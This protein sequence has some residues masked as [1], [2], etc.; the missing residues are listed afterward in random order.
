MK[1]T[2]CRSLHFIL[3]TYF[4]AACSQEWTPSQLNAYVGQFNDRWDTSPISVCFEQEGRYELDRQTLQEAI[5]LEFARAGITFHGWDTC[6]EESHGIRISFDRQAESSWTQGFGHHLDGRFA[7]IVM[8][9]KH[10]CPLPYS[11]SHCQKN[12][13][14]H[15][16]GHALGLRHE[17][18]RRDNTSCFFDQT[19]KNGEDDAIQISTFDAL[20]VMNY[21]HL[22][23]ANEERQVLSLSQGDIAA[24]K[25]LY[26]G[27]FASL[28][29]LPPLVLETEFTTKVIGKQIKAYRYRIAEG[30]DADCSDV[31]QY[32]DIQTNDQHLVLDPHELPD[33]TSLKLCLLGQDESGRWQDPRQFTS[34]DFYA[35]ADFS[36]DVE[37]EDS[38]PHLISEISAPVQHNSQHLDLVIELNINSSLP[39]KSIAAFLAYEDLAAL[40]SIPLDQAQTEKIGP[41]QYRIVFPHKKLPITGTVYLKSLRITDIKERRFELYASAHDQNYDG[42]NWQVARTNI[43]GKFAEAKNETHIKQ[44]NGFPS[45][46]KAGTVQI[47]QMLIEANL[48]ITSIQLAF[49]SN[50]SYFSQRAELNDLGIGRYEISLPISHQTIDGSYHLSSLSIRDITGRHTSWYLDESTMTLANTNIEAPQFELVGGINY[51]NHPPVFKGFSSIS[52]S[53]HF[54]QLNFI[55]LEIEDAS[56]I[57][58]VSVKLSYEEN[59]TGFSTIYGLDRGEIAG[60]RRIEL[61]IADHHQRGLYYISEITIQDIFGNA[62]SYRA[63]KGDQFFSGSFIPV[64]R[65]LLH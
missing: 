49:Q 56:E 13:A 10:S 19:G 22:Y 1:F 12:F 47:F 34:I 18:N 37:L 63:E 46:L 41:Q 62:M 65:I 45:R 15:E 16:M 42:S 50:E 54:D 2:I 40:P 9:L 23:Q 24:L 33:R 17:M 59:R 8:G 25:T 43:S 4:L 60:R 7:G 3:I 14:L 61:N 53:I 20:S 31:S 30:K 44:I 64:P 6:H 32:S 29:M 57:E 36:D 51:E 58:K 21:C 39:V 11:G 38:A 35:V 28:D 27:P 48:P 26:F 5:S 52:K 55:S